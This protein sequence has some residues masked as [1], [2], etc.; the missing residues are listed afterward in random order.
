MTEIIDATLL[1][2]NSPYFQKT[3]L[4]TG[5]FTI[6]RDE[7]KNILTQRYDAKFRS[8]VTKNIDYVIAGSNATASKIEEAKK[9]GIQI[10]TSEF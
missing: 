8:Q 5:S 2:N 3:F 9:L 10:I 6:K 7:I 4:I 1:Q